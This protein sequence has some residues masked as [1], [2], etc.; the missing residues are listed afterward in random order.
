MQLERITSITNYRIFK[1][2][3]WPTG[4]LTFSQVNL[5]YGW[6]GSGKTTLSSLFA[7]LQYKVIPQEGVFVFRFDDGTSISSQE[8][9]NSSFPMFRVFNRAFIEKT[10]LSI[11]DGK[12]TPIYYLGEDST[13]GKLQIEELKK[14]LMDVSEQK[15]Q[16]RKSV[17]RAENDID[18]FFK[19]QAKI[20]KESLIGSRRYANYNK[21]DFK[22]ELI[23][24][25]DQQK[26]II[27]LTFEEKEKL[28]TQRL[29]K[30]KENIANI[31]LPIPDIV[32]L[33][34]AMH[35]I[36][37][38]SVSSKIIDS[39]ANDTMISNWVQEG[40]KLHS[41]AEGKV[42]C[43]FCENIL[44]SERRAQL[45][46]HF[47][48]AYQQFQDE[49]AQGITSLEQEIKR[50]KSIV[51]P[52]ESRFYEHLV[53][54]V[55]N[56]LSKFKLATENILSILNEFLTNLE[57]KK[58]SAFLS[59]VP[60]DDTDVLA[61]NE[62]QPT[63]AKSLKG[64]IEL[65]NSIVDKHNTIT[66]NMNS[67]VADACKSL[68]MNHIGEAIQEYDVLI[69]KQAD[70]I[71][72]ASVLDDKPA[73]IESQI[74]AIEHKITEHRRPADELNAELIAY[75]GRDDLQFEF[76]QAGYSLKR[77][78]RTAHHL[79]EGERTAIA[80]LYFLKLLEDKD[81]DRSSGIV[82]IDD[83]VSSLDSNSLFSAFAYMKERTKDCNQLF[84]LTHNFTFFRQVKNWIHNLPNQKKADVAIRPGR[85]YSLTA[86]IND[87]ERSATL[88]AMDSLLEEFESEY[89]Y[90]FK[91]LKDIVRSDDIDEGLSRYYSIPNI[92]RR[93]LEM[94]FAHHLPHRKNLHD[95]ISST[96]FDVVK[97]TRILRF[98]NTYSHAGGIAAPEHD[99]S[100][101][102][103]TCATVRNLFEL[104]EYCDNRHYFVMC[105]QCVQRV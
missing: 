42:S 14:K 49:I 2:F 94:F 3:V 72:I 96:N 38:R 61:E 45:D 57:L 23:R 17:Q 88:T 41:K 80:F 79:S 93:L 43:L 51:L 71:S 54:D 48:D 92:A 29:L 47:N 26:N 31:E 103:E 6:N 44:S 69:A 32:S 87:G 20:I 37:Q 70:K 62:N 64:A 60:N 55:R 105:E 36:L 13:A 15:K 5:I 98:L 39:L 89:H 104:I 91:T 46:A 82:I 99:H 40:L 84:I 59:Q 27:P 66:S 12:I 50:I 28:N 22:R 56:S 77:N 67:E 24:L 81:F 19:Y 10:I 4:L 52:D 76:Q 86:F 95:K 58:A 75:L 33:R 25:V 16:A 68:E 97:K 1:N 100:I 63:S 9:G 101:L 8:L 11:N 21:N 7:H 83:P 78:G 73:I 34:K 65:I 74:A 18:D 90:L 35:D 85:F 102:A 30:P 53:E